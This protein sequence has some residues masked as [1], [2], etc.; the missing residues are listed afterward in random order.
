MLFRTGM[1]EI[2]ISAM[3]SRRPFDG[4]FKQSGLWRLSRS[5]VAECGS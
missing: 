1:A 5:R 3:G 4:G 2:A